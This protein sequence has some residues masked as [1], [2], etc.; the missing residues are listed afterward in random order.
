MAKPKE[1]SLLDLLLNRQELGNFSYCLIF[2][3]GE[4]RLYLYTTKTQ[5]VDKKSKKKVIEIEQRELSRT[6]V[7]HKENGNL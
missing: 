4:K 6:S 1:P 3:A 7:G 5:P 2:S